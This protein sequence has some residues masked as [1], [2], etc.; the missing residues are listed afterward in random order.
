MII[1][2]K[3]TLIERFVQLIPLNYPRVS[4]CSELCKI[5]HSLPVE[6]LFALI[7]RGTQTL[8]QASLLEIIYQMSKLVTKS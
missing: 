2:E 3:P 4:L 7:I 6:L 5:K 8:V 1:P